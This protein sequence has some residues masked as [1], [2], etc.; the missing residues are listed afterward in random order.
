MYL[1]SELAA[2]A[3]LSR[4]T[5]LYYEKLGLIKGLRLDNG[6]RYY[7]ENDLQRLL[8]IQQ[9]QSAGLSLKECE[10][11]LDAK[12]SKSL[13]ENRLAQLNHEI[14]KKVHAREL[15]MA[16]LGKRPQRELHHSLSQSAP[17]AYL[18]WLNMQGYSEKEALRLKWLSSNERTR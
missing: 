1:I 8:L 18:N 9:L 4:T 16:L 13:L 3:R 12:L 17:S 7:S 15:L 6:Y 5:L 10:Q 14:D 11:C 2:K